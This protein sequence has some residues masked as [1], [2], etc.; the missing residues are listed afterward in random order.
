MALR[1]VPIIVVPITLE[2]VLLKPTTKLSA[3]PAASVP[4]TVLLTP[5]IAVRNV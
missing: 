2:A 1:F 3:A 5:I 4:V